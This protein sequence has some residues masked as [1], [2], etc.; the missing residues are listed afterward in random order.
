MRAYDKN[1]RWVTGEETDDPVLLGLLGMYGEMLVI[2]EAFKKTT[3]CGNLWY[4]RKE[5]ARPKQYN[6]DVLSKTDVQ[7][8]EYREMLQLIR[9]SAEQLEELAPK[10]TES[11]EIYFTRYWWFLRGNF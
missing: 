6:T 8:L 5:M 3:D 9:P 11:S 10:A 2:A 4:L 7:K 1:N